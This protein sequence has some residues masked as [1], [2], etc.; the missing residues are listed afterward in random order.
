M[1]KIEVRNIDGT[2]LFYINVKYAFFGAGKRTLTYYNSNDEI[3]FVLEKYCY[4]IYFK[5]KVLI[6]KLNFDCVFY[7]D[8]LSY[9][10][11][12]NDRNIKLKYLD[13][14]GKKIKIYLNNIDFGNIIRTLNST[15]KVEYTANFEEN[16]QDNLLCLVSLCS[17]FN[18]SW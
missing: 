15:I 13:N 4:L 5:K 12:F 7:K 2:L 10:L 3:F 1:Y 8:K 17:D 18:F 9:V 16:S 6:N 11:S 14:F